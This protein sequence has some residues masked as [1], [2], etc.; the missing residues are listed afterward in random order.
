MTH[1]MTDPAEHQASKEAQR[2]WAW[3]KKT[4][5]RTMQAWLEIGQ[6]FLTGR[7]WAMRRAGVNRPHGRGYNETFSQWLAAYKLDDVDQADRSNLFKLMDSPAVMAWRNGLPDAVRNKL[8]H[9]TTILRAHRKA[10]A[11]TPQ[12]R[13]AADAE[14]IRQQA[15]E[16]RI[17]DAT[18]HLVGF[19]DHTAQLLFDAMA[20]LHE[21]FGKMGASDA[22]IAERLPPALHDT[23]QRWVAEQPEPEMDTVEQPETETEPAESAGEGL[24]WDE[25]D[26][27]KGRH[28]TYRVAEVDDGKRILFWALHYDESLE[29]E[30]LET[31]IEAFV[32]GKPQYV[33]VVDL[34]AKALTAEAAKALAEHHHVASLE[35]QE[36]RER[37][38]RPRRKR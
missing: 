20:A 25:G 1:L 4:Q 23:Y 36:R 10:H 18:S 37:Q 28:V 27:A 3:M 11:P 32:N 17:A 6:G 16:R 29:G 31:E 14:R 13:A 7:A 8:N 22:E 30:E 5:A 35:R 21:I 2:A 33:G 26:E 15:R 38:T 19:G 34:I 24:T 9:P 12:P